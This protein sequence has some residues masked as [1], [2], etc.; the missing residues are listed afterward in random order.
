MASLSR[1]AVGVARSVGRRRVVRIELEV[2]RGARAGKKGSTRR[3]SDLVEQLWSST[4]GSPCH[5]KG[6]LV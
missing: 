4:E 5:S 3:L 1:A 6:K 2:S